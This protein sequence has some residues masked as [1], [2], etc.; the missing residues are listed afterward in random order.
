MLLV[1]EKAVFPIEDPR[2]RGAA[3]EIAERIAYDCCEREE[4]SQLVY[5]QVPARG[6]QA[7]GNKQGVSG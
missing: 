7:G 4:R 1:K 2:A 3:N 6:E 5:I